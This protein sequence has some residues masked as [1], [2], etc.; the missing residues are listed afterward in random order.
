MLLQTA[1]LWCIPKHHPNI[2]VQIQTTSAEVTW[3][4]GGFIRELPPQITLIQVKELYIFA[5]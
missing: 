1:Y 3:K 4:H 2:L 5:Q